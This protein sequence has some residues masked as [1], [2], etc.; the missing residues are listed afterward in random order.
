MFEPQQVNVHGALQ[1]EPDYRD[2]YASAAAIT[3]IAAAVLPVKLYPQLSG[4]MMQGQRPACVSHSVVDLL[5]L[6]WFLKTGKWIDFSPRFIDAFMKTFDGLPLVGSGA[7]PRL[8]MKVIAKFGCA[9]TDVLPNDITLSDTEYRNPDILTEKVMANAAQY[10]IPGYVS[11]GLDFQ[12]TREAILRFG[13][14]SSLFKIGDELWTAKDGRTSW[15][16][17]DIDP[18]RT[19][20]PVTSGHQMTPCGWEDEKMNILQN[21]WSPAWNMGGKAHYDPIAWKPFV[22]EQWAI[23]K[24]PDDLKTFLSDLPKPDEFHYQWNR[25]LQIGDRNEDVKFMQIALMILGFLP[26]VPADELGIY[27]PKSATAVAKFQYANFIR[28]TDGAHFGPRTR[29]K[30]NMRFAV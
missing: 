18:L 1:S 4:P 21:E 27:G 16:Q 9:T 13:A 25:S 7:Y 6:Y 3:E 26:P 15:S 17:V 11:V 28:P 30:M 19:P 5:K 14:V 10:K 23:A 24:I 12:S 8:A 2:N 29:T 22:I 20:A